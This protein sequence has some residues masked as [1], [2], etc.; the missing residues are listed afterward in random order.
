MNLYRIQAVI[1]KEW[2][3]I[4]RDRLF[5]TLAFVV[6]AMLMLLFGYGLSLDVEDIPFAIVDHDNTQLSRDYASRYTSSR[7]F[8]FKGYSQ[9]ESLLS[10]KLSTNELRAYI[11]IPENFEKNLMAGKPAAVQSI[12]DGTFPARAAT[13]KGYITAINTAYSS[14][15]LASY[16][17]KAKGVS[18]EIAAEALAPVSVSV[19]YLYNQSLLS[20][21]SIAPK[22]I[23]V[24][25][26]VSPP[27]LTALGVVREKERGSIYNIYASTVSRAEFLIG[28][29]TPYVL[30]SVVNAIILWVLATFL[31]GAPFKGDFLF[32][33]LATCIYVMCT[34]GI[35]LVISV[36]VE[37]QVAA[38]V[39]TAIA[40][41]VPA[42]LYSGVL[43]P[44]PS[45]SGQA[46]I[47]AHALPAMY[48]TNILTG[49]FLKG[50]GMADLWQD[51]LILTLYAAGLFLVGYSLFSKRPRS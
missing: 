16:L 32:F 26:M 33:L 40:T 20:T 43:V 4:V 31:F 18:A 50:T 17:S 15:L 37:T 44:I 19:R 21:W 23:M 46:Q 41:V 28:K 30:M 51:V 13:S 27:F 12:L 6:P 47:I 34:T 8:D 48:Y 29:I 3:E 38:M 22:L 9:D 2:R 49:T 11:V 5:L 1:S 42:A 36:L 24:I 35:G 25:L 39:V 14:E 7:Y 45:L 10:K